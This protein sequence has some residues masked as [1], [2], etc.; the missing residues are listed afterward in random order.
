MSLFVAA[1]ALLF[2][3]AFMALWFWVIEGVRPI[4]RAWDPVLPGWIAIPGAVLA[5]AGA[6]GVLACVAVFV[7]YGRGTPAVF[8][9]PRAFVAVGPYRRVRNPMYLSAIVL[10]AG[11]GLYVRSLAVLA[12]A[13]GWFLLA[14]AFVVLVEE[15]GLSRRFGDTYDQYRRNVRRWVPRARGFRRQ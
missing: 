4:S 14:H 11:F 15:P 2:A 9:A 6:L 12:F 10:F 1:R 5:A 8:D 3:T 7:V 13:A